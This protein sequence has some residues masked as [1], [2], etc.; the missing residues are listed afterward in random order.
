MERFYFGWTGR[1][2]REQV[3]LESA[4][5]LVAIYSKVYRGIA[6][7]LTRITFDAA[8]TLLEP[9][10]LSHRRTLRLA[11]LRL[12]SSTLQDHASDGLKEVVDKCYEGEQVELDI[13]GVRERMLRI[14]RVSQLVRNDDAVSGNLCIRW[15]IGR[16]VTFA[17]GTDTESSLQR[18]RK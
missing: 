2:H 11:S 6:T 12:L 3:G 5:F 10:I 4:S 1:P 8:W 13:Q 7:M 18:S 15:L 16:S 14:T 9:Q 17:R